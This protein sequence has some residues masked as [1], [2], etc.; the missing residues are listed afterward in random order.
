[1]ADSDE[2]SGF[3]TFAGEGNQ[4]TGKGKGDYKPTTKNGYELGEIASALQKCI[5]RG[6]EKGME[7]LAMFGV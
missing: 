5:R 3:G 1:M 4:K 2:Q 7:E 6:G